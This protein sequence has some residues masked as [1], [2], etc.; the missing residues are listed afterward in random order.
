LNQGWSQLTDPDFFRIPHAYRR[1]SRILHFNVAFTGGELLFFFSLSFS[2][3]PLLVCLACIKIPGSISANGSGSVW[4][5]SPPRGG[6]DPLSPVA[7][8]GSTFLVL[9]QLELVGQL[10]G[11]LEVPLV[12]LPP[13]G[14]QNQIACTKKVL[15][16]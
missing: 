9:V 8:V 13:A 7:V 16:L 11:R 12:G 10:G 6:A 5:G 2:G 1:I 4:K 15:V 14:I 3:V